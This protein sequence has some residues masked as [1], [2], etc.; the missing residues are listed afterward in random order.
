VYNIGL[1]TKIAAWNSAKVN[2]NSFDLSKQLTELKNTDAKWLCECPAQSLQQSLRNLDKAY[3]NFFTCK[4][5]PKFKNKHSKQSVQFAQYVKVNL[6]DSTVFLP[7]LKGVSANFHR[8]FKGEIKTVT[9]SKTTT[10]KYFVSILVDN[11]IELPKKK[12]IKEKTAIGIDLGI[13]DLAILSD[14]TVF[15]NKKFLRNSLAN[16]RVQQRSLSRKKKTSNQYKKQ[17][18]VLAKL[19]ERIKNQREDYLHK[20]TT[21]IIK[22]YDTIVLENLNV[23]GM[24][25]NHN[26][27]LSISDMGWSNFNR[28]L[29]YKAEWYGKNIIRIGRFEPS[30]KTCSECGKINKELKLSDRVWICDYCMMPHERDVNAAKNIKHF[31][32]RNKPV[33]AKVIQ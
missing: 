13:K 14:E 12:P 15:E 4:G 7:K 21:S 31:W 26:L 16:L 24:V 2:Y 3:C 20:V 10:D 19:H 17:K 8:K 28:M 11:K 29:D 1:E 27:A 9:V 18:L 30:S 22:K 32:L 23:T 6:Q 33:N 25:K 5:F